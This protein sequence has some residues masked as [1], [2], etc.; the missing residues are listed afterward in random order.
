MAPRSLQ[1]ATEWRVPRVQGASGHLITP[2]QVVA[3]HSSS[4]PVEM[5]DPHLSVWA[6][7]RSEFPNEFISGL[8]GHKSELFS[9]S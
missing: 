4:F 5:G 2:S 7:L 1:R 3:L 6:A 8:L 9:G